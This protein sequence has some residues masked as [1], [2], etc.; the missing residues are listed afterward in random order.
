MHLRGNLGSPGWGGVQRSCAACLPRVRPCGPRPAAAQLHNRPNP[1]TPS[2]P[3][4]CPPRC[5]CAT[6][7]SLCRT[8]PRATTTALWWIPPIQ[9][10]PPRCCS[11]RCDLGGHG[12]RRLPALLLGAGCVLVVPTPRGGS[13][14]SLRTAARSVGE[15]AA[16]AVASCMDALRQGLRLGLPP[17]PVATCSH[18]PAL[19]PCP[20][21]PFFEAMHRALAPGGIVCT[22]AESLWCA[23]CAGCRLSGQQSAATHA[24]ILCPL[25]L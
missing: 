10:A 24:L 12:K 14:Q 15:C 2:L 25:P 3:R 20:L 9:W 8:P 13:S 23:A 21:Q 4:P 17:W 1:P 11:R 5:T 16:A 19:P 22:Q 6:A 18:L 7:S